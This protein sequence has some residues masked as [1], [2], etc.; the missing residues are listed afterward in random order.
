M[1]VAVDLFRRAFVASR[2]NG[3][4]RT[5]PPRT[6][7]SGQREQASVSPTM[8]T[9]PTLPPGNCV[10]QRTTRWLTAILRGPSSMN[11]GWD[12]YF[13]RRGYRRIQGALFNLGHAVG[14]GTIAEILTRHG[15]EPVPEREWKTIWKEFLMQHWD[16]IVA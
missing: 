12:Y 13:D 15:M 2:L 1:P 14:R 6:E 7:S 5:F 10:M 8:R 16:L 11:T 9:G 3:V 4:H